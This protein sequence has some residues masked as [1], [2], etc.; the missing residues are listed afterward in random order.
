MPFRKSITTKD[1]KVHEGKAKKERR[2]PKPAVFIAAA[3]GD[4][5]PLL[6]SLV[7]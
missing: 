4:F 3:A 1:T 2:A 5:M 6:L 7:T